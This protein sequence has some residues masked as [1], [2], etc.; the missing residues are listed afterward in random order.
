MCASHGAHREGAARVRAPWPHHAGALA[1]GLAPLWAQ[2]AGATEYHR[3]PEGPGLESRADSAGA[4]RIGAVARAGA[5]VANREHFAASRSVT[6]ELARLMQQG[7]SPA[8]REAQRLLSRSQDLV[9]RYR[10]RERFLAI[11]EWNPALAQKVYTFGN[12]VLELSVVSGKPAAEG[13]LLAYIYEVRSASALGQAFDELRDQAKLLLAD[14]QLGS[15]AAI[16]YPRPARVSCSTLP[17]RS[18]CAPGR[19]SPGRGTDRRMACA[20]SCRCRCP[21]SCGPCSCCP[22]R[23]AARASAPGS[24]CSPR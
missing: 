1:A 21:G 18:R 10:F 22:D 6:R 19:S 23:R 24:R 17:A 14:R 8:S 16:C 3:I 2:G 15:R 5:A 7:V 11:L 13:Q 4:H 9:V 12:R 20:R